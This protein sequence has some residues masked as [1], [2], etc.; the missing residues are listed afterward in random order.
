MLNKTTVVKLSEQLRLTP[1]QSY[2]L[3]QNGEKY[4]LDALVKKGVVLYAPYRCKMTRGFA[5]RIQKIFF[6]HRADLIG[7][8]RI[9][10][11]DQRGIRLYATGFF[12]ARRDGKKYY[13]DSAGTHI[14]KSI[15][16]RIV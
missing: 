10:V 5:D 3:E 9:L 4:D 2:I 13:A 14:E 7:S 16:Y 8:D 1:Y 12:S 15:F 11:R 6:G